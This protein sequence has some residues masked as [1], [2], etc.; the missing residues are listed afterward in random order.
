MDTFSFLCVSTWD[1]FLL[2]SFVLSFVVA[3]VF[4]SKREPQKL[5]KIYVS[6]RVSH[7]TLQTC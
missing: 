4:P 3:L 6:Y 5:H 2:A 1:F 7:Y